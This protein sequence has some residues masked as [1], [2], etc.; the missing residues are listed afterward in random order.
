MTL[1]IVVPCYNEEGNI[2]ALVKA[3]D[4]LD[5]GK[6]FFE[7]ILVNNGSKDGT[8]SQIDAWAKRRAYILPV[9]VEVNQGYGYGIRQ[10]IQAA[11][12]DWIG[13]LHADLQ[14]P[15]STLLA[16]WSD[17]QRDQRTDVFY[18]SLRANRPLLDRLFTA[19]MSLFETLLFRVKLYDIGATP[20]IAH[21]SFFESIDWMPDDFSF[22]LYC[23]AHA[24]RSGMEVVRKKVIMSERAG[25]ES[26]WNKGIGSRFKL[27]WR[28]IQASVEIKRKKRI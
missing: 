13:W 5:I 10:G 28:I 12:G 25:G 3:F 14:A 27:S 9:T 17:I 22:D 1:S 4:D 24:S 16:F 23:Y 8:G 21:R 18:K 11:T 19:G 15:P 2:S 6:D 7:L 26:S 20:V